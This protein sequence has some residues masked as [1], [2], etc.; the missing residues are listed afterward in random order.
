M[1]REMATIVQDA[2]I[3]LI[4]SSA[5]IKINNIVVGRMLTK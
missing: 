2:K 3:N 5:I 1:K 4:Q